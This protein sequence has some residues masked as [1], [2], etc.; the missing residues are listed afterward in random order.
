M[1]PTHKDD[2]Y[3][4]RPLFFML[5]GLVG[6]F[7]STISAG[8]ALS[9]HIGQACGVILVFSSFKI[10]QWRRDYRRRVM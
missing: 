6:I 1:R 9:I 10:L 8:T 4:I 7:N 2:L 5:M 3:E